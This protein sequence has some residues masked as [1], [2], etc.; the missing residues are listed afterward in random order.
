M[1]VG[2]CIK[3]PEKNANFWL[4][5]GLIAI[6]LVS[7]MSRDITR[8][9]YGLH[10]WAQ[11]S[12]AWAARTHVRYGLGYTRGVTTWAVGQPPTENPKIYLDHPQLNILVASA[13]M[14]VLGTNEWSPRVF[15][16]ILSSITLIIFLRILRGLS[17]DKTTLLA[18]LFY[19]LFP[20]TSY[21]GLG[22]LP[23]LTGSLSVWCYLVLIGAI[24]NG[25]QPSKIHKYGL[26]INLFLSLQFAWVG[27]FYALPIGLHYISRCTYRRQLPEKTLLAILI[28]SPLL[29][30]ALDFL[31]MAAGYG[32]DFNKIVDLYKWRAAEGEV[33]KFIWGNWFARLWEFAVTNFTTPTLVFSIAYLTFGQL[34]VFT[35]AKPEGTNERRLR[36]FPLFWLFFMI[37]MTQLFI[38]K[39]CLWKHQTWEHPL[40]PFLAI[41]AASGIMLSA[42][43][44]KKIHRRLSPIVIVV[45]IG[46]FFIFC[47]K[48]TNYYYAVRWQS[49]EKIKLFK[50]L[51]EKIPPDKALLSFEDFIVN[52]HKAKG[53][54]YRPE[55]AWYL[56]REIVQAT[57]LEQ[58][59][60]NA[61]TGKFPYYL[62]P[63]VNQLSQ[64]INSLNQTYK[65][66]YIPGD[67]GARTKDGKFLRA[68]MMPYII[69]DL[70]SKVSRP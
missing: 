60:K 5:G 24:K 35:Q 25:P 52:Q 70:T 44:L 54:F 32:W 36:Q 59:Q 37:P 69:F 56:D 53:G 22:G 6:L 49:P 13:V 68:G 11:A 1:Q 29:S 48:G 3:Q 33:G 4:C 20:L 27:F 64:L 30:L 51:N 28:F 65:Y 18:G 43:M 12:G 45:L 14:S 61:Q 21:F 10:S 9:F 15:N 42:D 16:I 50:M 39:G 57:T 66:Q 62:V 47:V 2:V 34:L 46:I 31:I 7:I 63:T 17:D 55:I 58:I 41:A 67:E 23:I 26:A 38:L 40:G 8:P 19:A